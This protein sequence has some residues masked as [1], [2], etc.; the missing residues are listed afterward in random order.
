M[1]HATDILNALPS[2]AN[3][4]DDGHVGMFP[5]YIYDIQ[6]S[7]HIQQNHGDGHS[8]NCTPECYHPWG[9]HAPAHNA[10][11]IRAAA[12]IRRQ[13]N[14]YYSPSLLP[15]PIENMDDYAD[16]FFGAHMSCIDFRDPITRMIAMSTRVKHSKLSAYE[17]DPI[18]I[19]ECERSVNWKT[20]KQG[21]SWYE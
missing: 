20:A 3:P 15:P 13:D 10:S 2:S 4:T 14:S 9:N 1:Y 7:A 8:C 6:D 19:Q 18:S 12:T 17:R 21:N 11:T 16:V 5:D